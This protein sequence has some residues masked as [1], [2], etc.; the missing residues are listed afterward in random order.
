VDPRFLI[1]MASHDVAS[2]VC[3][4][5]FQDTMMAFRYQP[6]AV[7]GAGQVGRP[8]TGAG[9]SVVVGRTWTGVGGN[10]T[11]WPAQGGLVQVETSGFHSSTFQLNM[12]H[13]RQ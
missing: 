5:L 6:P 3:Q 10:S 4:A 1:Q 2:D 8:R 9:G 11:A 13:F 12:S 7:G